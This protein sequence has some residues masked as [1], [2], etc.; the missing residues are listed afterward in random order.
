MAGAVGCVDCH[1]PSKADAL[2]TVGKACVACHDDK[3]VKT[4][5]DWRTTLKERREVVAAVAIQ[6]SLATQNLKR[7]GGDMAALEA[8]FQGHS[9]R[10]AYLDKARGVHNMAATLDAFGQAERDLRGLL[11]QATKAA[12][13]PSA[14]KPAS[15]R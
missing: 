13:A 4:L 6:A 7:Q 10:L 8:S 12:P 11:D 15:E 14:S 9:S 3:F 5:A 1:D 2:Q